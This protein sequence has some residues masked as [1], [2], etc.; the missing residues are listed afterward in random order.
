[1]KEQYS[2][3]I[4]EKEFHISQIKELSIE[5]KEKNKKIDELLQIQ[6]SINQSLNSK[7]TKTNTTN[8]LTLS[9]PLNLILHFSTNF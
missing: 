1:M 7:V 5:I 6:E 4:Q 8:D 3:L 9:L 2:H